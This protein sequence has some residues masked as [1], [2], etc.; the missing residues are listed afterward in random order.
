MSVVTSQSESKTNFPYSTSTQVVTTLYL[1]KFLSIKKIGTLDPKQTK[2]VKTVLRTFMQ[3]IKEKK[4]TLIVQGL[5]ENWKR[6]WNS[7][8]TH[9]WTVH[10]CGCGYPDHA[11]HPK[12]QG[13]N[14]QGLSSRDPL[15]RKRKLPKR[16][17]KEWS[18]TEK[19]DDNITRWILSAERGRVNRDSNKNRRDSTL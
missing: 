16:V 11:N 1:I 18:L 4:E 5:Y 17:S 14:L 13:G 8:I 9:V 7:F 12:K 10:N 15:E 2:P 19:N 3:R 6:S